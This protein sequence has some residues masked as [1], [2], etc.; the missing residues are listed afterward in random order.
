[1]KRILFAILA[2]VIIAAFAGCSAKQSAPTATEA[3]ASASEATAGQQT[4][5]KIDLEGA[6]AIAIKESGFDASQVQFTETGF[7]N[8]DG[9]EKY[10]VKFIKDGVKYEYE[11]DSKSGA[12]LKKNIDATKN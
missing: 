2:L 5:G 8:D 3:V 6:K 10:V 9:A 4:N 12:I 1:M 7:D 11:I